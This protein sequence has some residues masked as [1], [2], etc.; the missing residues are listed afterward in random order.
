MFNK[1]LGATALALFIAG[2]A[3]AAG[4]VTALA[5]MPAKGTVATN[6]SIKIDGTGKCG[7]GMAVSKGG[8]DGFVWTQAA[9]LPTAEFPR[10]WQFQVPAG[11]PP[12][13][14]GMYFVRA[15]GFSEAG[16]N[17]QAHAETSFE[18]VDPVIQIQPHCP[19]GWSI[20]PGSSDG[21]GG[22]T[23]KPKKPVAPQC[24][25]K[26]EWFDDGCTVGCKRVIY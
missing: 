9:N 11:R 23:C 17:T 3:H 16:C 19:D 4:G 7:V 25:P 6:F 20:V 12:L 24:P 21:S 1:I 14:K 22:Y 2:H 15:D 18:V 5:A 26:H 8:P 10:V 13:S